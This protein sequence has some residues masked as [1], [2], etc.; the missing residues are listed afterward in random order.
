M[1]FRWV[2]SA[3][4]LCAVLASTACQFIADLGDKTRADC[5]D[6]PPEALAAG[7]AAYSGTCLTDTS[8]APERQSSPQLRRAAHRCRRDRRGRDVRAGD[9]HDLRGRER[10]VRSRPL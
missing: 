4:V 5:A 9:G 7:A 2:L 6:L 8:A 3:A 10:G 1:V